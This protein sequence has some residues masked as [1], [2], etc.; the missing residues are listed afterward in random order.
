MNASPHE[1][2]SLV[3]QTPESQWFERK[4]IGGH[5]TKARPK[6]F[7]P[8]LVGFA[9]GEGGLLVLGVS[10][11][12]VPALPANTWTAFDNEF[13]RQLNS[14]FITPALRGVEVHTL[15]VDNGIPVGEN[16]LRQILVV[17]IPPAKSLHYSGD[18]SCYLRRGDS[19]QKLKD[20]EITDLQ[21]AR[22]HLVYESEIDE[23]LT[24]DD[25]DIDQVDRFVEAAGATRGR[26]HLLQ[27]RDLIHSTES[28]W[29]SSSSVTHDRSASSPPGIT[30]AANLLFGRFPTRFEVTASI[31]VCRF[32]GREKRTGQQQ[33]LIFDRRTDSCIPMAIEEAAEWIRNQQPKKKA[34]DESTKRFIWKGVIPEDAWFE[35][36]VN[37]AVHRAY[38]FSGDH[39]RVEIFDDR[40]EIMNPGSF[41]FIHQAKTPLKISRFARNPRIARTCTDLGFAQELGEGI[42]RIFS[43][44]N[45]A[46]LEDPVYTNHQFHVQLT[47]PARPRVVK[48]EVQLTPRERRIVSW[49]QQR[50][51]EDSTGNIVAALQLSAPTVRKDLKK[52]ESLGIIAWHGRSSTDPS[53]VWRLV[54]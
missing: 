39:I 13:R 3:T 31:R 53:A 25:L 11:R 41:R 9:N 26:W 30:R 37:A 28:A 51:G 29:E 42:K 1:R 46:G 48:E 15:P 10:D 22:G 44:M 21:Y 32:D 2:Y 14:D 52:L 45:H 6:D 50:H 17:A 8:T 4:R 23:R 35:G 34:L 20:N 27:S 12:E 7:R 18:G 24:L 54:P 38:E 49:L 19:T 33:N 5:G 40:I 47:L 43:E 16:Q 36:L